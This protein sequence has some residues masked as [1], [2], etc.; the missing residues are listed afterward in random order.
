M[1]TIAA[2]K[3]ALKF[4]FWIELALFLK[5]LCFVLEKEPFL[6]RTFYLVVPWM[7]LYTS[8]SMIYLRSLS[9]RHTKHQAKKTCPVCGANVARQRE[10]QDCS[11]AVLVIP[12]D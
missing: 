9:W 4:C 7:F 11:K 2:L 8:F 12:G 10:G 5:D 6:V 3:H 1:K